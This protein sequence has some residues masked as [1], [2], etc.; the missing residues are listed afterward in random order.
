[1]SVRNYHYTLS[2]IPEVRR[3]HPLRGGNLKSLSCNIKFTVSDGR[4]GQSE[5]KCHCVWIYL[6][7][8]NIYLQKLGCYPVA[9]VI[10]HLNKTWNWLLLNLSR[11]GYMRSMTPNSLSVGTNVLYQRDRLTQYLICH[12]LSLFYYDVTPQSFFRNFGIH[13]NIGCHTQKEGTFLLTT[14]TNQPQL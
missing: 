10:L 14:V 2:N 12:H 3:S 9:V 1:M 4:Y 8:N 11:E 13:W 5:S 6:C 7:H